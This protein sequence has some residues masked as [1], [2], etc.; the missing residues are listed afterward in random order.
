MAY[1]KDLD[2]PLGPVRF[3]YRSIVL[4]SGLALK[5]PGLTVTDEAITYQSR[6]GKTY[7][8]G[9]YLLENIIQALARCVIGEQMLD[10]HRLDEEYFVA[11]MTHDE[12]VTIV[13]E[14]EVGFAFEMIKK[15][16]TTPPTWAPDLPLAVEGAYDD[17]YIK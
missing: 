15:I 12:I 8:W 5:Y 7:I 14:E 10:I 11:T 1:N 6:N 16:M 13:P 17:R 2:F 9:G 4:P 3:R